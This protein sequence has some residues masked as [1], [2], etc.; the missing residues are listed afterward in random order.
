MAL[1]PDVTVRARGVMEKC[2]FCIH[3]I[4]DARSTARI[5][6]RE[7][8]EGDVKTACQMTCP[9]KAIVFGDMNNKKSAVSKKFEEQ[10]TYEL[11]EEIN[12]V[13]SVRYITKIWN[14][15]EKL[16]AHHDGGH[17]KDSGHGD[18]HKDSNADPHAHSD[19]GAH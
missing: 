15:E 13:P 7:L 6:K 19:K 5:D 17:G 9:T 3:K 18:G 16:V 10:R 8:K 4:R 14:T 2:T 11:L 12:V 1:N